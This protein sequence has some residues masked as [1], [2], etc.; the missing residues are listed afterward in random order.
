MDVQA[1][2]RQLMDARGWTS[3]RLSKESGL[4][5]STIANIFKRNYQPSLP[6]LEAVCNGL[7]ISLE[8][9]FSEGGEVKHITED[10]QRLVSEWA[11]LSDSERQIVYDLI[12]SIRRN[13]R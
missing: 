4:S 7:K 3:Y 13:R 6:T 5:Q 8:Q 2:I 12:S 11:T 10:Q 9:F 1:R